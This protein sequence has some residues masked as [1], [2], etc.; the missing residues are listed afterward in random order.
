[1]SYQLTKKE[2]T[3]EI[4]KSGKDPVYFI[5]TYTKISHPVSGLIPFKTY[6]YQEGLLESFVD[7]RFNII[8]KARQLGISTIVAAYI[9]WLMLFYR[10]KNILIMA[11]K[12]AT[13]AN[14]V[15]K[16]KSIIKQLPP[17][18]SIA[19]ISVDNRTSFELSNGSQI[20]ASSTSADAGRSEALSLLVVDEAAHVEGLDEL[21][22][23]LYPTLSTGGNCIALSSPNGVG[24]WFYKTY[25]KADAGENDF[26]PTKL[27]WEVHPEH[28]QEWFVE[29]TKNMSRRQVAQELEC[30]FNTSGETV[31]HSDDVARILEQIK[32]PKYKTGF[33]RNLWI[34]EEYQPENAYLLVADVARGD[35]EDY[36]TFHVLKVETMEQ[37][38][39]YRGKLTPDLFANIINTTG[40][41]YGGCLVVVENATVGHTVLDKLAEAEYPNLYYS[42]KGTHEY[43][44]QLEAESVTNSIAG[45]T[46]SSKTK[47]LIVAKFEEF[48]RNRLINIYSKRLLGEIKTFIWRH[49]RAAA[50]RG[51]NDDLV[52][53]MAIACWVKDTALTVNQRELQYRKAFLSSMIVTNTSLDTRIPGMQGYNKGAEQTKEAAAKEIKPFLWLYKG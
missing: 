16:V 14:L 42:T 39:E 32:E 22:T 6:D 41:E 8:L 17:W 26:H 2:V 3:K 51:Y 28:D 47:P 13:A 53:S 27:L 48:V 37:A 40:R 43:L 21:W 18:I 1:M 38:A 33:D 7:Y 25:I 34:W 35:G 23:A 12:F 44:D 11:T 10:D 5:N 4:I 52:M 50:M 31:I 24:N 19:E 49:G 9:V 46:T 45:F 30:N 15:K 20:K 36:S 29:E